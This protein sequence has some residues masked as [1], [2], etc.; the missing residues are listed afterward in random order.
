MIIKKLGKPT[1][2]T[3]PTKS[4]I[5]SGTKEW[6]KTYEKDGY[7]LLITYD[8]KTR[9]IIDFFIGT[10]ESAGSNNYDDLLQITNIKN[11][12]SK[13][14]VEPVQSLKDPNLYTGI[15]IKTKG[16]EAI[17]LKEWNNSKAGKLQKKYPNWTNEECENVA[18][19]KIWI[20]MSIEML[21]CERGNPNSANPSNYGD[22][23]QWQWCWDNY[24]PSC[25]YGGD[26]GIITS[27]N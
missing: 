18:N 9:N 23:V 14:I 11:N 24:T 3:E 1:I 26:N 21:K 4:Q 22:G 7:S 10:K 6:D 8:I 2:N 25:F 19:N 15:K 17:R 16:D 27:Y 13:V 20:G 5:K 12:T